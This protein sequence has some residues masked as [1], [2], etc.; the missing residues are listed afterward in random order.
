[1]VLTAAVG[2]G[3]LAWLGLALGLGLGL[4]ACTSACKNER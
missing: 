2:F 3:L 4:V 1:M